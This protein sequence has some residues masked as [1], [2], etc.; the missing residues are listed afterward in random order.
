MSERLHVGLTSAV[1][2]ARYDLD[3]ARRPRQ[4]ILNSPTLGTPRSA[5]S[6]LTFQLC[7]RLT[8]LGCY[9]SCDLTD[10]ETDA[11]QARRRSLPA[12][13]I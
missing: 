4:L 9:R 12:Q 6:G 11:I 10:G 8:T 5:A 3:D 13:V 2:S 1:F 7:P